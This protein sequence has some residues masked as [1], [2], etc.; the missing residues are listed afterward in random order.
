ME[1]IFE[2][3]IFETEFITRKRRDGTNRFMKGVTQ[4]DFSNNS[5]SDLSALPMACKMLRGKVNLQ[6]NCVHIHI[7]FFQVDVLN[8]Q[9]NLIEELDG[10]N[11][12][13]CSQIKKLILTGNPIKS[14]NP[15]IFQKM[16]RLSSLEIDLHDDACW[17]TKGK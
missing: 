14:F 2:I 1:I 6:K 9:N 8:L 12:E 11:F 7:D 5:I 16:K 13:N 4:L 3:D 17:S 15:M 10:A